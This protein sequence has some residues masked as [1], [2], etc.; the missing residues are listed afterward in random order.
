M[1]K[2]FVLITAS[3]EGLPVALRAKQEGLNVVVGVVEDW[4][5]T[6]TKD[7]LAGYKPENPIA[8]KKRLETYDGL[9]KKL[10]AQKV[11]D[12]LLQMEE[13]RKQET[14]VYA[15]MNYVL[16]FTSQLMNSGIPGIYFTEEDRTLE[17]DRNKAKEFVK[18]HYP[19]IS[20]GDVKEFSKVDD[21]KKDPEVSVFLDGEQGKQVMSALEQDKKLYEKG[22]FIL[23]RKIKNA[24]EF[25]PMICF[26]DGE[27]V[28]TDLDIELK[29]KTAGDKSVT[30]GCASNLVFKTDPEDKINK[31]AFPPIVYEMAKNRKGMFVIDASILIDPET[32]ERFFGEF[33]TRLGYDSFF[34]E[35]EM[36]GGVRN[37][38]DA[39]VNKQNPFIYPFGVA[40]R[41][42]N[43]DLNDKYPKMFAEGKELSY[44]AEV[45]EH[46]WPMDV[47][48]HK[49]K[50]VTVG[51]GRDL[52]VVTATGNDIEE[53]FDEL[54]ELIE[55]EDQEQSYVLKGNDADAKTVVPSEN[56]VSFEDVEYRPKEDI[57]SSEYPSSIINRFQYGVGNL[58]KYP[59]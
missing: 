43:E 34:T 38:F 9:L 28:F 58:Y 27:V 31:I 41:L 54:Y 45:E 13:S 11:V 53:A 44:D 1:L 47:K 30:V 4:K 8:R 46:I 21:A 52:A 32:D 35:L 22:G 55:G 39:V 48:D 5:D 19:D 3:G 37:F 17:S 29:K 25:T 57:L 51:Y 33:C 12:F 36:A 6:L 59:E 42:F 40:V 50:M 10:P 20:T 49:G 16:K 2:N 18:K 23:E 26:Y 7:E 14:F 24:L 15:D 56:R